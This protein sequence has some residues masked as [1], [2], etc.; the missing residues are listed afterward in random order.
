MKLKQI[1]RLERAELADSKRYAFGR[2]KYVHMAATAALT[3]FSVMCLQPWEAKVYA[4]TGRLPRPTYIAGT[5]VS[6]GVTETPF[7]PLPQAKWNAGPNRASELT[8]T[9][10]EP[11]V[12]KP[13]K[14]ELKP[15][16]A[17][18]EAIKPPRTDDNWVR[19]DKRYLNRQA[20]LKHFI[21]TGEWK[22]FVRPTTEKHLRRVAAMKLRKEKR[23]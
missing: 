7:K 21:D 19:N 9:F 13:V 2:K 3:F 8:L 10:T 23:A 5:Y 12:L 14:R 20:K 15:K 4:E 1:E 22:D 16:F 17:F 11:L 6:D 18:S